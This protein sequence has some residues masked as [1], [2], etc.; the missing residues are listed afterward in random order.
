MASGR[1]FWSRRALLASATAAWAIGGQR[2][3]ARVESRPWRWGID[4]GS[5]TNPELARRYDL[6]VLEPD[7]ARPIAPLRGAHSILLGYISLGEVEKSRGYFPTLLAKG[8]LRQANPNWPDARM[9]DLRH[10]AW[11][12]VLLNTAIPAILER[13]YDGIFIDTTDNA[14]AMERA[15]P[16]GNKDMVDA[17]AELILAIRY[18]FPAIPIMLNRGYAVL[19]RVAGAVTYVLAEAM[20]SRWNFTRQAYERLSD[21]DWAWQAVRVRNA[22]SAN[23]ALHVMTLDY[24][25]PKDVATVAGFYARERAAGFLPYVSTVALDRLLGEPGQ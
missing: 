1:F 20:A 2:V 12:D 14:E 22:Q 19:P 6:L 5:D 10:P 15:D 11:R 3:S 21:D 23:P 4:Y 7:H 17:A 24:W 25:D 9:A 16:I 18:R 8:A 13:G